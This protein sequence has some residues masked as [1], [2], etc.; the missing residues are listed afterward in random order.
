MKSI[1]LLSELY[2]I[3]KYIYINKCLWK[4]KVVLLIL[5]KN[6][7]CAFFCIAHLLLWIWDLI[8]IFIIKLF[9]EWMV[10]WWLIIVIFHVD[11]YREDV[12]KNCGHIHNFLTPPPLWQ[13]MGFCGHRKKYVF[14]YAFLNT[15][16]KFIGNNGNKPKN[17]LLPFTA[18]FRYTFDLS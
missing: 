7:L 4:N 16:E 3:N 12:K 5:W 2:W 14:F 1:A 8:C 9:G 11:T 6:N 17:N 15:L 13:K 18:F 10:V